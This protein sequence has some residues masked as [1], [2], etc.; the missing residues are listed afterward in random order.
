MVASVEYRG[1]IKRSLAR[2]RAQQTK[3]SGQS[4]CR[5]EWPLDIY[6]V[7]RYCVTRPAGTRNN[8]V[9][10]GIWDVY[11]AAALCVSPVTIGPP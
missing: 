8:A 2:A 5:R 6:L 3:S 1:K 7:F 10:Y 4:A 11:G 9:N